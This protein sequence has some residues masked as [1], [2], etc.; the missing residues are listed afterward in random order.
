MVCWS[1]WYFHHFEIW[2]CRFTQ[3]H[4][5]I[6]TTK[7]TGLSPNLYVFNHTQTLHSLTATCTSI[8]WPD[9]GSPSLFCSCNLLF[10]RAYKNYPP[11]APLN[12]PRAAVPSPRSPLNL[13]H[14][15]LTDIDSVMAPFVGRMLI[16]T[17]AVTIALPSP[18]HPLIKRNKCQTIGPICLL[19]P[20]N[21]LFAAHSLAHIYIFI[22]SSHRHTPS[23]VMLMWFSVILAR[24][25]T[26]R[27]QIACFP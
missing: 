6:A 10:Q 1:E 15:R 2:L 4:S 9:C 16:S 19:A 13:K 26:P 3:W 18:H 21:V 25:L 24:L 17:R 27:C 8:D 7:N 5:L 22:K 12:P 23:L 20:S 14:T 11:R